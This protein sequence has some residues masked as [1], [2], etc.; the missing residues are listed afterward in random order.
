MGRKR[1]MVADRREHRRAV[2]VRVRAHRRAVHH[3]VLMVVGLV[4]AAVAHW[5]T[6][7]TAQAAVHHAVAVLRAAHGVRRSHALL[8][9]PPITEPHA[10]HLLLQLQR[11][12]Q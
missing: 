6:T 10:H 3:V 2:R 9:L 1:L 7:A 4:Q 11:V 5:A 12:G 8:L